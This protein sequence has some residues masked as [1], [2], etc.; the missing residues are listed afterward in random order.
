MRAGDPAIALALGAGVF[1]EG[2]VEALE[3]WEVIGGC[4]FAEGGDF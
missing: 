1:V 4:D 2:V 3:A